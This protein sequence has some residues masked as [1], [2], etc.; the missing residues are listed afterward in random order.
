LNTA[1]DG[2]F[3]TL[4]I[5]LIAGRTFD[6]HDMNPDSKA[7]VVDELF[8]KRYFPN[9][10][11]LGQHVGLDPHWGK[12][13][14]EIVGVVGNSRYNTLR[15][16]AVPTVY[17]PY[18]PA[19]T[20]HFAVR[21]ATDPA[22]LAEPARRTVAA[23]DPAVPLTEFHTQT[24]LIDR[25]LRTER[26]L[27]FVSSIFGMIALL[28]AAIGLGGLLAYA[29]ARRTNEIGLR[30]ALGAASGDVIRM[31]L[32]D[33]LWMLGAGIAVGLPCAYAVSRYLKTAL[34]QLDPLDPL[35]TAL[36]LG[37]LTWVA[38][39]AAWLPAQRAARID[40]LVALREE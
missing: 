40:P 18:R 3:E 12:E 22:A 34:F 9:Q 28:L 16:D 31:V 15:G 37:A 30:M 8:A 6:R 10:N 26:L 20:V 38:L 24:A 2:F 17:T 36:A 29:V 32:R 11:P 13:D 33:V 35:S 5:P 19:A 27:G 21:T 25:L 14:Y 23:I 7:M 1:S 39:L 4:R